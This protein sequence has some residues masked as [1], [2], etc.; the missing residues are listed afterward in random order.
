[1]DQKEHDKSIVTRIIEASLCDRYGVTVNRR[2]IIL[3]LIDIVLS[4]AT[5]DASAV[6]L[7]S[8]ANYH[9]NNIIRLNRYSSRNYNKY[10]EAAWGKGYMFTMEQTVENYVDAWEDLGE[11]HLLSMAHHIHYNQD[12]WHNDYM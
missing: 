7:K 8:L 1:M 10:M 4:C 12:I 3:T 5:H 11:F 2:G 9:V 6:E